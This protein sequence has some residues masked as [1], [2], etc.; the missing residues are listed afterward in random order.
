[1][2]NTAVQYMTYCNVVLV[3]LIVAK[4]SCVASK[5]VQKPRNLVKKW[6]EKPRKWVNRIKNV[7]KRKKQ[8]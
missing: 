1:M 6:D 4:S 7:R 8:H 5:C 3:A 2:I